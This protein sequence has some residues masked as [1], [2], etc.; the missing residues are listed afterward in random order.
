M[1][2]LNKVIL[3]GRTGK[4]PEIRSF[5]NGNKV[6]NFT[7]ATSEKYKKQ[8]GEQVENTEWHNI[9]VF[10][11]LVDIVEKYVKKGD[12]LYIE[13][14]LKTRSWEANGEK[15]YITEIVLQDYKGTLTMLG[16]KGDSGSTHSNQPTNPASAPM[17]DN[18][19]LPF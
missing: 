17:D 3:I 18:Q 11:K 15:K 19:D 10:G 13:G 4:E 7:L 9:S 5:E 6:A 8:N 14:Q 1:S 2:S 16:S 12:L